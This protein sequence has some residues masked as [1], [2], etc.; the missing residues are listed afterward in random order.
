MTWQEAD[1]GRAGDRKEG[2]LERQSRSLPARTG[3]ACP[4]AVQEVAGS[5]PPLALPSPETGTVHS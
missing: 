2:V 3:R 4:G 1:L 5:V